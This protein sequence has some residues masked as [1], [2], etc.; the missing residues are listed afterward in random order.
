MTGLNPNSPYPL[1]DSEAEHDR[2]I[3][4]GARLAPYTER[5]LR[6]AGVGPNQHVLDLGSGVG[7]VALVAAR[8]VGPAGE[9]VG[10]ERDMRS[11]A[12]ARLRAAEA[13]FHNVRFLPS[14]VSEVAG[15][16]LF[17][18][19]VGRFILMYVEDPPAVLRAA[20]HLVRPGGIVAFQEPSYA[21]FLL[22]S[23]HLP[24]WSRAV[25][26]VHDALRRSGANTEMG[27][28]LYQVFQ[29]ARLPPPAMTLEVPLGN[30]A[31]FT[32]WPC[33]TLRSLWPQVQR[34][35][36]SLE[37]LG[38]LETLRD[39][40]HAEIAGANAVVPWQGLVGAFSR[41]PAR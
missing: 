4:Q 23:S 36:L 6:Q 9:V 8:L 33:D 29:E 18:A 10:V 26:L 32:A 15:N 3:R 24:L 20:C 16:S 11:V 37:G 21:P 30:D 40:L 25:S 28:A 12:R 2:L 31:G 22:L 7:E 14:D 35:N 17:D 1:G 41:V 5:F 34:H 13:G 27:F 19:V 38:D 39:R